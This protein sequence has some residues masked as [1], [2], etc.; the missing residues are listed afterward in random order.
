MVKDLKIIY[1]YF[2]QVG[3]TLRSKLFVSTVIQQINQYSIV[4][5][6]AVISKIVFHSSQNGLTV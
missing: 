1:Q 4:R 3:E 2:L 5:A 6:V